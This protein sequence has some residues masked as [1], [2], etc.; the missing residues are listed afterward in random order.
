MGVWALRG[1][2]SCEKSWG[3]LKPGFGP[4]GLFNLRRTCHYPVPKV[5]PE[6]PARSRRNEYLMPDDKHLTSLTVPRNPTK[7]DSFPYLVLQPGDVARGLQ[8]P[9]REYRNDDDLAPILHSSVV[10]SRLKTL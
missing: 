5:A 7:H 8:T 9:D 6:M 2:G 1:G 10:Y 4:G 3:L